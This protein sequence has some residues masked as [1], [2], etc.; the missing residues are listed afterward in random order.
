[1]HYR[2]AE[3]EP[4]T[5]R[6][7]PLRSSNV[8]TW[9]NLASELDNPHIYETFLE[10]KKQGKVR[11]LGVTSHNCPAGVLNKASELGHYDAVM[12]AYNVINGGYVDQ[13]ILSASP[14]T[15]ASLL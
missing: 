9:A 13:A 7:R 10:S 12:V 5:R 15:S 6:H 1:M 11:F 2:F 3:C 14:R 8:P 4:Q